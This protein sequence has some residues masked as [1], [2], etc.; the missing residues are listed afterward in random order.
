[1]ESG[2]LRYR[3][4]RDVTV[5]LLRSADVEAARPA[6]QILPLGYYWTHSMAMM[7]RD[8]ASEEFSRS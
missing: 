1:M 8:V 3:R 5:R 4:L 2:Q 6:L 7:A